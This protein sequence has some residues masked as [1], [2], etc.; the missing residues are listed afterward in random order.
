MTHD[1]KP[2][3]K[4]LPKTSTLANMQQ[5]RCPKQGTSAPHNDHL[6]LG[7]VITEHVPWFNHASSQCR[8]Q[9]GTQIDA[10]CGLF[11]VNHILAAVYYT[12]HGPAHFL[13]RQ[14]FEHAALQAHLGDASYNLIQPGAANYDWAVLHTNFNLRNLYTTPLAPEDLETH[15]DAVFS[16]PTV[17]HTAPTRGYV[18]RTPQAGGHWIALLPATAMAPIQLPTNTAAILCDSLQTVPFALSAGDV[19]QLLLTAAVAQLEAHENRLDW[20]VFAIT[21]EF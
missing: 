11:A 19:E 5:W 2:T 16:P 6:H 12:S 4:P 8:S 14:A 17:Q 3:S 20:A 7:T 1:N 15:A 10:T 9:H 21:T 13:S 18:L